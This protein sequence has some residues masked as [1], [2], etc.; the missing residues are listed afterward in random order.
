MNAELVIHGAGLAVAFASVTAGAYGLLKQIV[1]LGLWPLVSA[2]DLT[3]M[4]GL[5]R[6]LGAIAAERQWFTPLGEMAGPELIRARQVQRTAA[7]IV[8]ESMWYGLAGGIAGWALTVLVGGAVWNVVPG[9]AVA[10]VVFQVPGWNLRS[11]AQD[12]I[13]RVTRRLP[14]SLE[15]VVLATEAGASFEEAL[16]ILVREDPDEPLHEEFD[17]LLRDMQLGLTRREALRAMAERVGT[18]DVA[19]L[20]MAMDVSDDLGTPTGET[21]K[22][23]AASI[24]QARLKRAEKLSREAGPKMAVPN[25]LIMVANVLLILAPFLPKLSSF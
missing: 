12:R 2:P 8:G 23:Q 15:V 6:R 19:A 22:K 3:A 21:L 24:Q 13:K 18:D 17:Q 7:E 9:L 5:H 16:S 1:D 25:T 20:A 10:F 14:Y 4:T 11:A